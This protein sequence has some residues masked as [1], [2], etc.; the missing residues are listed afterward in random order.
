M[1]NLPQNFRQVHFSEF[2][3]VIKK[4]ST[5]P[6]YKDVE[7][8]KDYSL[9]TCFMSIDKKTGYCI[10]SKTFELCNVF[11]TEKGLGKRL[12]SELSKY[13]YLHLNCFDGYLKQFYASANFK[14]YKI[15]NNWSIGGP[16]VLY[17]TQYK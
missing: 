17:M 1:N 5:I 15:E 3:A 11:S 9:Y 6:F 2:K 4:L 12:I 13:T 14:V 10:N 8:L 16:Q 7:V